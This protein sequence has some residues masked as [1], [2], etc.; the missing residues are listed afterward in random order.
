MFIW[1]GRDPSRDNFSGFN[2]RTESEV[3]HDIAQSLVASI[4]AGVLAGVAHV[5]DLLETKPQVHDALTVTCVFL[6]ILHRYT[7]TESKLAVAS[8]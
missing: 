7:F 4:H 1:E 5:S 3:A 6:P 2:I 8:M